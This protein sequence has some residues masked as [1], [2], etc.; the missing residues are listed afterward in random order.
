MTPKTRALA[1]TYECLNRSLVVSHPRRSRRGDP[2]TWLVLIHER[3]QVRRRFEHLLVTC[4]RTSRDLITSR[5]LSAR[6][7]I[8]ATPVARHIFQ[9]S[10][11]NRKY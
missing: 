7:S 10:L 8:H 6:V 11:N 1:S 4:Q 5:R 2:G 9:R 3:V